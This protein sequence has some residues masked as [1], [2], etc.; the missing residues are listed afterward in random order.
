M[1]GSRI[2]GKSLM[3]TII[4]QTCSTQPRLDRSLFNRGKRPIASRQLFDEGEQLARESAKK[5]GVKK[6]SYTAA[7]GSVHNLRS[8]LSDIADRYN[9]E[10]KKIIQSNEPAAVKMPHI[11]EAIGRG[12]QEANLAA[13]NC[14][15]D[16]GDAGQRILDQEGSRTVF[17]PVRQIK[18]HRY[19]P[20]LPCARHKGDLS[21]LCKECSIARV[22]Q[23]AG[24]RRGLATLPRL[25]RQ[26]VLVGCQLG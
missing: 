15:G 2:A 18:W 22:V 24:C 6:D 11:L 9:Q 23:V 16:I 7:L 4:S 13:A 3:R 17:S 19:G 5:N 12:Q 14:G 25:V 26:V 10:I 20:A 21:R 8:K 1:R